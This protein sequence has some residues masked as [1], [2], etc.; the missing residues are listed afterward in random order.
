MHMLSGYR[1]VHTQEEFVLALPEGQ[2][3]A[4]GA[5]AADTVAS[6]VAI[7]RPIFEADMQE[8]VDHE[9]A[10]EYFAGE[11]LYDAH[12]AELHEW[13]QWHADCTVV[14]VLVPTNGRI[15]AK[16]V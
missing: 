11:T 14:S 9:G 3:P 13:L 1:C 2:A 8:I 12:V 16:Q 7:L 5:N 10:P 15:W 4:I 6:Y